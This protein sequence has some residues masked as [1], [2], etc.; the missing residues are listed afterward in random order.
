MKQFDVTLSVKFIADEFSDVSYLIDQLKNRRVDRFEIRAKL[1]ELM[2]CCAVDG[3]SPELLV[4][5][6]D[7]PYETDEVD[8]GELDVEDE[9]TGPSEDT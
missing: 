8:W 5:V 6:D 9:T 4:N 3:D 1:M 7:I 2:N